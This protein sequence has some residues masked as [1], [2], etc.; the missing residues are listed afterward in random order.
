[1]KFDLSSLAFSTAADLKDSEVT[2]SL[3]DEVL[4][5]FPVDNT[6][7]TAAFDEY[8]T[9]SVDVVLPAGT[10]AGTAELTVTGATTG[11]EVPVTVPTDRSH[12]DHGRGRRH[13][14]RDRRSRRRG[15]RPR[16]PHGRG[17]RS[18]GRH[19][20]SAPAPSTT[21]A[22]PTIVI[23]G[24]ALAVG[25]NVLTVEYAGDG[26]Q[27]L[28]DHRHDRGRQGGAD[29]HRGGHPVDRQGQ[30]GHLD[31]RR[32]RGSRRVHPRGLRRGVRGRRVP[33]PLR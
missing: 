2:V 7:G 27:R 25:T 24:D 28:G 11:T 1:M 9:A 6:I 20:R 33:R 15:R 12:H 10:P 30:E 18:E 29:R 4:G 5:T 22:R 8:G 17:H 14:V 3:G 32:H 26:V 31:D 19:G 13:D 23:P 21:R 16:Q